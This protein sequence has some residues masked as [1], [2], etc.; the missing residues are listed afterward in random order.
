MSLAFL[1]SLIGSRTEQDKHNTYEFGA[2]LMGGIFAGLALDKLWEN[3]NLPGTRKPVT[4]RGEGQKD[5][6]WSYIYQS[7][8]IW[9]LMI[10]GA[11]LKVNNTFP[12]SLGMLVGA[13]WGKK[14]DKG[15]YIGGT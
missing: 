13:S 14:S 1:V 6:D 3:T 5:Y 7:G 12:L 15:Q 2:Y 11:L 9:A 4:I 10:S 8:L